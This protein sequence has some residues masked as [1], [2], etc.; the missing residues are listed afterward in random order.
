MERILATCSVSVTE[1]KRSPSAVL[2]KAG[3]EPV[4]VLNH[5]RPA[6]YLVPPDLF[7][8]MTKAMHSELRAMIEEGSESG[9]VIPA[10]DIFT[11]L[12]ERYSEIGKKTVKTKRKP[13]P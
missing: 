11:E 1:L 4:A 10:A 8:V 13:S 9:P 12:N 3:S 6:A 7:E 5:N 2:D